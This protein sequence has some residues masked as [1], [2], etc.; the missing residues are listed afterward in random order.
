MVANFKNQHELRFIMSDFV[1]GIEDE[2]RRTLEKAE[3]GGRS[4]GFAS[5][6][7]RKIPTPIQPALPEVVTPAV[8]AVTEVAQQQAS[9]TVA[10]AAVGGN[11]EQIVGDGANSVGFLSQGTL[12][13]LLNGYIT[14]MLLS[15]YEDVLE[16]FIA[17]QINQ[18]IYYKQAVAAIDENTTECCLLVHGQFQPMDKPFILTGSPRFA[19]EIDQPPFHWN[20]RTAIALVHAS[21]RYDGLTQEMLLAAADELKA[22]GE[23]DYRVEIHPAHATSRR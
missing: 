2:V 13:R 17:E 9:Q 3:A 21:E 16:A 7:L 20:C 5:L 15:R 10:I 4:A 23:T 11:V 8:T 12:N 14:A 6:A 18:D 22:R 1:R 19:D